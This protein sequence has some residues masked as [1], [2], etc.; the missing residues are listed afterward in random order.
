MASLSAVPSALVDDAELNLLVLHH[1]HQQGLFP[2]ATEVLERE[3]TSRGL[4]PSRTDYSGDTHNGGYAEL[5][6]R[7]Q[8]A[9]RHLCGLLEQLVASRTHSLPS[10]DGAVP[11]ILS[12]LG[13]STACDGHWPTGHNKLN[14]FRFLRRESGLLKG[15]G[16]T[17]LRNLSHSQILVPKLQ[18]LRTLRGHRTPVYCITWDRTGTRYATGSDDRLVKIWSAES[19]L[20]LRTCR[21]HDGEVTDF[22]VSSCNT[23]LASSSNDYTIRVWHMSGPKT[24]DPQCVLQGHTSAVSYVDF[25]PT[26]PHALLSSSFDGTCRIWNVLDAAAPAAVLHP[27]PNMFGPSKHVVALHLSKTGG[28]RDPSVYWAG[29]RAGQTR[30][31]HEN[32]LDAQRQL[33]AGHQPQDPT[34]SAGVGAAAGGQQSAALP[35]KLT[36][37]CCSF[38]QCGSYVVAG[39]NDCSSYLWHWNTAAGQNAVGS[40]HSAANSLDHKA[41]GAVRAAFPNLP[42]PT[43]V[44]QLSGHR[45]D[46]CLVAFGHLSNAVASASKDGHVLVW[47]QAKS[48]PGKPVK[49]E[50]WLVLKCEIDQEGRAVG[51]NRRRNTVPEVNQVAWTAND[52]MIA[53]G[54]SD[55]T[56]RVFDSSIDGKT[57][58]GTSPSN[59]R[60]LYILRGHQ[61]QVHVLSA[62]PSCPDIVMSAGYDGRV[63]VWCLHTGTALREF[64]PVDRGGTDTDPV[65][66]LDGHFSPDGTSFV[67]SDFAGQATIYGTGSRQ[68]LAMAQYDQ[69]LASDYAPLLRDMSGNVIDAET[70][71][72]PHT[73]TSQALTDFQGVA[74][75]EP[76]QS[77]F[78]NGNLHSLYASGALAGQIVGGGPNLG[79]PNW[80]MNLTTHPIITAA[81]WHANSLGLS[82]TMVARRVEEAEARHAANHQAAALREAGLAPQLAAG[83]GQQGLGST[84]VR[85]GRPQV[86]QRPQPLANASSLGQQ[87]GAP[88][89]A[90]SRAGSLLLPPSQRQQLQQ[91][92]LPVGLPNRPRRP[93]RVGREVGP[94]A[95]AGPSSSRPARQQHPVLSISDSDDSSYVEED[96]EEE[97]EEEDSHANSSSD[98]SEYDFRRRRGGSGRGRRRRR[99]DAAGEPSTSAEP[100]RT[101]RGRESRRPR[102]FDEVQASEEAPVAAAALESSDDVRGDDDTRRRLR[103][104]KRLREEV[105]E[106]RRPKKKSKKQKKRRASDLQQA[107]P[108][109]EDCYKWLQVHE[110]GLPSTAYVPQMDDLVVYLKGVHKRYLEDTNDKLTMTPW[111]QLHCTESAM[112]KAEPCRVVGMEYFVDSA[113]STTVRVR[114][115]FQENPPCGQP[116]RLASQQF[117]VELPHSEAQVSADF[118]VPQARFLKHSLEEGDAPRPSDWRWSPGDYCQVLF[119]DKGLW[120][121]RVVRDAGREQ[122]EEDGTFNPYMLPWDGVELTDRYQVVWQTVSMEEADGDAATAEFVEDALDAV[123][124]WEML[125]DDLTEE[126]LILAETPR[127]DSAVS[128]RML[129]AVRRAMRTESYGPFWEAPAPEAMWSG[130][131]YNCEVP[132][133]L[134]LSDI[135]ARLENCWYR[136][137]AAIQFDL[138]LIASNAVLYNGTGDDNPITME[139]RRLVLQLSS[140]LQAAAG[141]IQG[142]GPASAAGSRQASGGASSLV[143]RLPQRQRSSITRT[144]RRAES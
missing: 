42:L 140:E 31:E 38:S 80:M 14:Y 25:S 112:R 108:R 20:L 117:N 10:R 53:T 83:P 71:R 129:G 144:S 90:A 138:D 88:S 82:V 52:Q 123:S 64:S 7:H 68:R 11:S 13:D 57:S 102:F 67:L 44:L 133:P 106:T 59:G 131:F 73:M 22:A 101:A 19:G 49:F 6:S 2:E 66:I 134:G 126:E 74:Y 18:H 116:S 135:A 119:E 43:E 63:I 77:A 26:M 41:A 137:T 92:T 76:Y 69:F 75:P 48:R 65:Q 84:S 37:L 60:L 5:V 125:Q 21:G 105:E 136:S 23:Y 35:P 36:L 54:M 130:I 61:E 100:S 32:L 91:G 39:G 115:A 56:I 46:I 17:S 58:G 72:P 85:G 62:H 141:R 107:G 24:G 110:P 103:N 128:S 30:A 29:S 40:S 8:V 99:G 109:T 12:M 139:A 70:Q 34:P 118:L 114:L 93:P 78:R 98:G 124:P 142:G 15:C 87:P 120:R 51:R 81:Y 86:P 94:S 79:G 95:T 122:A 127:V 47:R 45:N 121:G 28:T 132:L 3:L 55:N 97:E 33:Q 1:L 50:M 96:F 111:Q 104:G 143:V 16:G 27:V 9:P 89:A 4:L 113:R